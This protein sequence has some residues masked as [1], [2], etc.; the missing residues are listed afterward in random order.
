MKETRCLTFGSISSEISKVSNNSLSWGRGSDTKG[1]TKTT[2]NE[3]VCLFQEENIQTF[4]HL[5]H[6]M[7]MLCIILMI[8]IDDEGFLFFC[9][10]KARKKKVFP[11]HWGRSACIQTGSWRSESDVVNDCLCLLAYDSLMLKI[12][13]HCEGAEKKAF[14][15]PFS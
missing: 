1:P 6:Q 2:E 8:Y 5:E 9:R 12:S 4:S 3:F 13:F 7:H 14:F 10:P 15:M 11:V